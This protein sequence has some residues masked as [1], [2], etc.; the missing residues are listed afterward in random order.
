MSFD[1]SWL[2]E[3]RIVYAHAYGQVTVNDL[4]VIVDTIADDIRHGEPPVY[5]IVDL[6]SVDK[7]PTRINAYKDFI[8]PPEEPNTGKLLLISA[9][10]VALFIISV[11]AQLSQRCIYTFPTLDA[12]LSFLARTD[13]SLP[14]FDLVT[15][16][17]A[18]V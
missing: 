7:F 13:T 16:Q 1:L 2:L 4:Q 17:A 12:G 3:K 15:E 8:F 9:N 14:W 5:A 10:K 11:I 6:T 18:P